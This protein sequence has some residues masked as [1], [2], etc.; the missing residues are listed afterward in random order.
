MSETNNIIR[1]N[2]L[3]YRYEDS[4]PIQFPDIHVDSD[5]PLLI[6]GESGS[7]K[8]TLLHMLAGLLTPLEGTIMLNDETYSSYS[9]SKK[10]KF[11]GENIGIVF[12]EAQFVESLSVI[13]NVTLSPFAE[14]KEKAQRV[15]ERLGVLQH[16][17]TKTNKLS[18]GQKQRVSI[19]RATMNKARLILADEP[20]SALDDKNCSNVIQLLFEVA[21]SNNSILIVVSHDKRLKQF[22]NNVVEL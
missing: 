13:E 14:G 2:K 9:E 11:R 10:D 6:S 22:I 8:T 16:Q 20:T 5:T 7:G 1:T 17:S 19:A 18:T 15:L 4:I 21:K 12:Q 3:S